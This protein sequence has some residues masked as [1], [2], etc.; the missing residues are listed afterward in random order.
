M[1]CHVCIAVFT[2]V[3]CYIPYVWCTER[4]KEFEFEFEINVWVLAWLQVFAHPLDKKL[5]S[6]KIDIALLI[7]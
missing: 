2:N 1:T 5:Y 3:N 6:F 7:M 4:N